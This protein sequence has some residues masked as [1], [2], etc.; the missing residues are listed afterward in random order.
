MGIFDILLGFILF[1][2]MGYGAVRG[3]TKQL[4]GLFSFWL[5]LVI[6]LWLYRPFSHQILQG[7]FT[8]ASP[9]VLDSFA[10][11]ILMIVFTVVLQIILIFSSPAPEEKRKKTKKNI[12]IIMDEIDKGT[13]VKVFS[14]LGGLIAGFFTTAIWL[15]IVLALVQFVLFS[16]SG[17]GGPVK[18]QMADSALLPYFNTL[19]RLL[20]ISVKFFTPGQLPSI[21]SG[22]L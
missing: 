10:F 19:L 11:I 8:S 3:A 6:S 22:V 20:Y 4:T 7:V 2:G 9:V 16:T 13:G 1:L 5:A 21:F 12:N 18:V 14:A 17:I 15:S